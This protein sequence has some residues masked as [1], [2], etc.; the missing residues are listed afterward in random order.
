MRRGNPE[1]SPGFQAKLSDHHGSR[2]VQ[3]AIRGPGAIVHL[4]TDESKQLAAVLNALAQT[5][6]GS[7]PGG[8]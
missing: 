1:L 6:L 5:R 2:S 7:V 3:R 8:A 4:V